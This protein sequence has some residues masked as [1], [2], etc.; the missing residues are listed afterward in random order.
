MSDRKVIVVG[1]GIGDLAIA[2]TPASQE[3]LAI[4]SEHV[5]APSGKRKPMQGDCVAIDAVSTV[6]TM[7]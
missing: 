7:R 5:G 4:V 2:I 1:S 6:F 3:P